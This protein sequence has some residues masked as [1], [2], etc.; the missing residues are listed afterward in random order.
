MQST[1]DV[2]TV[3]SPTHLGHDPSEAFLHAQSDA[4]PKHTPLWVFGFTSIPYGMAAA[5]ALVVVPFLM[6]QQGLSMEKVG[7][8]TTLAMFPTFTQILYSPII[9][10]GLRRRTWLVL[11]AGI[12]AICMCLACFSLSWGSSSWSIY[13]FL[14][15][16]VLGQI[17][18]GLISSCNGGLMATTVADAERG[19]AGGF[20]NAG[21]LG[22]GALGAGL[23]ILLLKYLSLRTIGLLCLPLMMFPALMAL[24]INEPI[25][26]RRPAKEIFGTMFQEIAQ[27]LRSRAGWTGLLFCLSPVGTVALTNNFSALAIDY[28]ASPIMVAFVNGALNGLVSAVGSLLGGYLADRM[29]RRYAYL[30]S[31]I[32]TILVTAGM[33]LGPL[34]PLTYAIGVTAYFFVAGFAY[35]TYSAVVLESLGK[36][37]RSASTQYALFLAAGNLAITYVG[38]IDTRFSSTFGPKSVL[39]VDGLLNLLGVLV[40]GTVVI[41]TSRRKRPSS[42]S[43]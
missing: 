36:G 28:H 42:S 35:S 11:L 22:G 7:W 16:T 18:S 43:Q 33:M 31:G 13:G 6:R 2:T 9:D 5:F 20:Y 25:H 21:N 12:G 27:T 15:F 19:K 3:P 24:L 32:V 14:L 37:G 34:A 38:F 1:E 40:L 30:I 39:A 26:P 17:F 29:N 23:I 41:L 10:I 4:A 8:F